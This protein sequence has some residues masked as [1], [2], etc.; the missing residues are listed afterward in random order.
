MSTIQI[1]PYLALAAMAR[2]SKEELQSI[3]VV[4]N[5]QP[6]FFPG[7]NANG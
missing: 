5:S 7:S 2:L 4:G 6:F 1:D 3:Q